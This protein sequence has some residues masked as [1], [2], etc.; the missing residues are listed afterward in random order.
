MSR[1]KQARTP[2]VHEWYGV[3]LLTGEA[4]EAAGQVAAALPPDLGV[5]A[6]WVVC[7]VQ[8]ALV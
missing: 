8:R 4:T 3:I 7:E 6:T 2:M 1:P 5:P